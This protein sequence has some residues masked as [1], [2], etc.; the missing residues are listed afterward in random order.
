MARITPK[1]AP[2]KLT[3]KVSIKRIIDLLQFV[4]I[5]YLVYCQ[6]R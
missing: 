5:C 2:K 6:L 1:E 4:G 3:K